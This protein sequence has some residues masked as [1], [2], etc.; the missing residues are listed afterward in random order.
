MTKRMKF[1]LAG[2]LCGVACLGTTYALAWKARN[3]QDLLQ[4]WASFPTMMLIFAL[5]CTAAG[6]LMYGFV[7]CEK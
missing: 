4:Y 6:L 2:V 7:E 1:I 5:L 3:Y